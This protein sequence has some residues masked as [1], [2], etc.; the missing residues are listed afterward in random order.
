MLAA[1]RGL[2]HGCPLLWNRV[3]S[4]LVGNSWGPVAN[5]GEFDQWQG[6]RRGEGQM[7]VKARITT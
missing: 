3:K 5:N 7:Q 6:I 1:N 4:G 2:Q